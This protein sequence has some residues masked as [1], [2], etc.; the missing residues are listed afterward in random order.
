MR[1]DPR[2]GKQTIVDITHTLPGGQLKKFVVFVHETT[3]EGAAPKMA[4]QVWRPLMLAS[5]T[6]LQAILL[7]SKEVEIAT[8][9]RQ[10]VG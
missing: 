9:G 2:A 10:E 5:G 8:Q 7:Y 1:L 3:S 6:G 4:L